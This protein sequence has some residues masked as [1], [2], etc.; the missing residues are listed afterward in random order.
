[1]TGPQGEILWQAS[2]NAFGEARVTLA[3]EFQPWRLAGQYHDEETGL[4]YVLARYYHPTL[5]R[6]L[7][8]DPQG[9]AG[10]S[11]NLYTYCDGDPVNKIDPTGELAFLAIV[12]IVAI[13]AAIGAL[14]GAGIEAWKQHKMHPDQ[15]LDW[16]EIGT[17]AWKG[18]VVGA[19]GAGV[20]LLLAPVVGGLG[21][22]LLA[23]AAGGAVVGGVSAGIEQC[24]SNWL[25]DK[26]L[27]DGIWPAIGIGA[28][29]GAVTAGIG[30]IW[31]N[32]ARRAAQAA[33]QAE[34]EAA[35]AARRAREAEEAARRAEQEAQRKAEEEA[36]REAAEKARLAR[37]NELAKDPAQGGKIT[38]KTLREADV[39]MGLESRGRLKAPVTREPTGGADF[40]DGNG[41]EWDVKQFNSNFPPEKGGFDLTKSMTKINESLRDGENVIVDSVNMSPSDLNA[42]KQAVQAQGL[43]DKVIFY[44]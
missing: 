1:M 14:V 35:E 23:A 24:V 11:L 30:G 16:G 3:R 22:G 7:T 5:G 6:F 33:R 32:R 8:P 2:Y 15:P 26:P 12:G 39:A 29:I 31:A 27:T 21:A 19:V 37:R 41:Q 42:L 4:C 13:G 34:L 20:G 40:V 44:P 17:E 28:A 43:G 38:P 36:A 10:G 25:H 18:A 9:L